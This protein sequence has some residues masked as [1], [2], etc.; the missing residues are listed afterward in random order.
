MRYHD[1]HVYFLDNGQ[2]LA[3]GSYTITAYKIT[4]KQDPDGHVYTGK[5]FNFGADGQ[6]NFNLG[7]SA[8]DD[9]ADWFKEQ[10]PTSHNTFNENPDELNFAF[11]G[12]LSLRLYTDEF[13]T[14]T[15]TVTFQNITLAQGSNASSENWWFGGKKAT[16]TI[17]NQVTVNGMDQQGRT[18]NANFLRGDN[19][20]HEVVMMSFSPFV[21]EP[22]WMSRLNSQ[23]SLDNMVLPGSHDT[24]MSQVYDNGVTAPSYIQ[25]QQFNVG[26]QLVCGIR[27]FDLRLKLYN[28]AL[29]T[30]HETAGFGGK[31]Q[32]LASILQQA[33]NFLSQYP[34]ETFVLK[35]SHTSTDSD[36]I[37][38][39]QTAFEQAFLQPYLY[40]NNDTNV[41]LSQIPLSSL[42]GKMLLV[43]YYDKEKLPP[44]GYID[45]SQ[46]RFKYVDAEESS[47]N[48]NLRVYDH[49]A[50]KDS[51]DKMYS[52]QLQKWKN[53]VSWGAGHLFLLSWTLTA[54]VVSIT[55]K[56]IA[57]LAQEAN[58]NLSAS[59]RD[60][61]GGS[62]V[63]KPNIIYLDFINGALCQTVYQYNFE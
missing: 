9:V 17:G 3:G 62:K 31:G 55:T 49:Y 14:E 8:S 13:K 18:V 4:N 57:A 47:N 38:A 28:N 51:F 1:N 24:G 2:H 48:H 29:V 15:T 16:H 11:L 44:S 59:L 6:L 61:I 46:G 19:G 32:D 37:T 45:P 39:M 56:D 36:L 25:T 58:R 22:N 20:Q 40:K 27:Y 53:H 30:Y 52:D 43:I 12:T 41:N 34:S 60:Q 23:L 63:S 42:R 5:V 54:Q 26:Q 33:T 10:S 21:E 35:F 50:D 7:R